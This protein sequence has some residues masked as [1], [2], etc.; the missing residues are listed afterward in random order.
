V[1]ALSLRM[2]T[3]PIKRQILLEMAGHDVEWTDGRRYTMSPAG[4]EGIFV[5]D[6]AERWL[7]HAPGGGLEIDGDRA[8]A[9]LG[10]LIDGWSAAIVHELAAAPASRGELEERLE[11]PRRLLRGRLDRMRATGLLATP[12]DSEDGEDAPFAPTGWLRAGLAPLLAA[13]RLE[14]RNS[15]EGAAPPT[16]LDVEAA[17]RLALP[18][19]RLPAD[20]SGSCAL[21]VELDPE[22]AEE[23]VGV[24]A[25][26]RKGHVVAIGPG[27]DSKAGARAEGLAADW[28]DTVVEP[29]PKRVRTSG[30]RLLAGLIM[31]ELHKALFAFGER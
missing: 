18:L 6:I 4:R 25:R 28:L 24:T 26:I 7:E 19:L 17:F 8:Q 20:A 22:V 9:A 15:H 2:A 14:L 5:G 12:P 29:G 11:L 21:A 13:A 30:D 23:P 16:P 1:G 31:V 3:E 10:A 27:L